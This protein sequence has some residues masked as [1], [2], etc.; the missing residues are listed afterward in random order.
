[1]GIRADR[2]APGCSVIAAPL[3]A[4]LL[5][6]LPS[7]P[8]EGQRGFF[9]GPAGAT[10][11]DVIARFDAD[12]DGILNDPE[13]KAARE[14]IRANAG[15]RRMGGSAQTVAP[16][17]PR[18]PADLRSSADSAPRGSVG[19]YDESTL[20]TLYLRFP[21][22][23]WYE[24]LTDFYGTGVDVPADLVVDGK[25][26]SA[27]GVR[28][29]GNSSY[30]MTGGSLK[31][32]FNISIDYQ[33]AG[34]RLLG[35]RTLNLLNAATD[36]SLV[37][38]VLYGRIA[39][40]Y[41][42]AP[43]ANFMKLVINGESWGVYVNVEQFNNDFLREWYGTTEG[44]RWK[45]PASMGRG[46][47]TA[48]FVYLGA[49]AD[50]YRRAYE[51]KSTECP[52]A[53]RDLARLCQVL[54]ETPD[55]RLEA[56]LSKI[57]DV[58]GALWFLALENVFI[59]GDGYISRAS[60][61]SLYEDA[62]GRF[63]LIPYDSNETFRF[64]GGGG[65]NSWPSNDPMLSPLAH[66]GSSSRP[67]IRR[68]LSLPSTRERYLAH[69][70]TIVEQWLDWRVLE[71]V[72]V[73]YQSLID[74]EVKADGK[75]LTS[76]EAF[77][78]S[79]SQDTS[80]AGTLGGRGGFGGRETVP[81]LERFVSERRSFLLA[82]EALQGRGVAI[83]SVS[84]PQDPTATESVAV[85]AELA[86]GAQAGTVVL[87]WAPG[88]LAPFAAVPMARSADGRYLGRIPAQ[89]AGTRVRFYV[90]VRSSSTPSVSTFSPAD[91]EHGAPSYR[92]LAAVA[93]SS[94]VAINE[95]MAGPGGT[96]DWI[97]LV[98]TNDRP[99][100]LSGM[101]LS[102]D[103]DEPRRWKFPAGTVLHAGGFLL[104][105]A[106]GGTGT[107]SGLH[108]GFRL[109]ASGETVLLVDADA[110]GNLILD[111]TTFDAQKDGASWGRLPDGSG[112]FQ[113]L[114]PTPG[115]RNTP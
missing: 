40:S 82:H 38:E 34:Q 29:R 89:P 56:E 9:G 84:R 105:R 115:K 106:D 16:K 22:A 110:R 50:S 91:A 11:G 46:G 96:D 10:G 100:D 87:H 70:R 12:G 31:K 98:N 36:P 37:R 6:F 42:P 53:W 113:S 94:M 41:I 114:A 60:D 45:V 14:F 95:V 30:Q 48:G 62:T 101:H 68:L 7:I 5:L 72:V 32:S 83:A 97:E 35:Y 3:L 49:E 85:T 86:R 79:R 15:D 20:R 78:A 111:A 1:M 76:Y 75:K 65:P 27:V 52:E 90:E 4:A 54:E 57:L 55:E 51:L 99:V 92:V 47:G 67:L 108:A 24:E 109:S 13:R 77:R 44:A 59:D 43:K 58:D 33:N 93:A 104:V 28:F 80:G 103:P 81:S 26:Y 71:P 39:R 73:G 18:L 74:A 8:A 88:P 64:A 66:E 19:L 112:V 102:D 107:G 2:Q 63:H 69:Y 23:D 61:F 17:A 25:L 21:T